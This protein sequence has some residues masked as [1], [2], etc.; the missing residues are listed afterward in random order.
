MSKDAGLG[1][2]F[3]FVAIA[4]FGS[5]FVVTK[6]YP[7]GDGMFFQWVLCAGI[8]SV[9]LVV[10]TFPPAVECGGS[11]SSAGPR[12]CALFSH[13]S[14][15][16]PPISSQLWLARDPTSHIFEPWACLGGVLWCTGLPTHFNVSLVS[17]SCHLCGL[18]PSFSS[19]NI[20]TVPIIQ[21]IGLGLGLVIWGSANML[22][23]VC[24]RLCFPPVSS[25]HHSHLSR[26]GIW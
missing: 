15:R 26:L 22:M 18:P 1:L 10:S 21:C 7:T 11:G 8:W 6:K 20:W 4:F 19:G 3:A 14:C 23:G 17:P 13:V 16:F 24:A 5:N 9:G 2:A 25:P 12:V